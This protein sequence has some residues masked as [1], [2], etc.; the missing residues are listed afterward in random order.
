MTAVETK[1][2][3]LVTGASR[4]LGNAVARALAADGFHVVVVARTAG[5]LAELVD[6]IATDG[7]TATA[8]PLDITD[9]GGVGELA[10]TIQSRWGRLDALVHAAAQSA[11]LAP[12]PSIDAAEFVAVLRT[13]VDAVRH[14][15]ATFDPLLRAAPSG[16]AVFV[17]DPA[18]G[19]FHGCQAAAKA[20][21]AAL[22]QAYAAEV[23]QSNLRV[24]RAAP[25]PMAT[26]MRTR[27]H[28]GEDSSAL[29]S[30]CQ[31]GRQIAE[32]VRDGGQQEVVQL[33]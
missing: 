11:A 8:A 17:D 5:A 30:P 18:R 14:L 2:V 19:A 27:N 22:V 31:V 32:L 10:R 1:P 7:G 21:M 4:G 6:A 3:A 26:R 33:T 9:G 15:L 12:V 24:V 28:P 16:I 13:N 20:A 29:A 23:K 25:P